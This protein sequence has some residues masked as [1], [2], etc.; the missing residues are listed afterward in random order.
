MS[1]KLITLSDRYITTAGEVVFTYNGLLQL[2]RDGRDFH[3]Y[4]VEF[5]EY[6]SVYNR[7]GTNKLKEFTETDVDAE[8]TYDW[9][10]PEP[11]ASDDIESK[12]AI[13]L[14]ELK[15]DNEIYINRLSFELIEIEKRHMTDLIRH[16][17][18]MINHFITNDVV[19]GVGRGSSCASLVLFLLGINKIDPIKYDIP[20]SEFLR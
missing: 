20:V 13:R 15:L 14:S 5:N 17:L 19:W 2:A 18:Y 7:F 3:N 10:T 16:L 4:L 11:F 6:T 1:K 12:C 8:F 9:N